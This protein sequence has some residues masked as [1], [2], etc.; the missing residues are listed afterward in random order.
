MS[1]PCLGNPLQLCIGLSSANCVTSASNS[2]RF[3]CRT[4]VAKYNTK[5][6]VYVIMIDVCGMQYDGETSNV[7]SRMN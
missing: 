2:R 5:W 6:A 7:R 3:H 1:K 4:Q